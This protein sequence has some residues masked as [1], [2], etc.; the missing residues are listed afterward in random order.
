M[1]GKG[2][3]RSTGAQGES[4]INTGQFLCSVIN[5]LMSCDKPTSS[6]H[7]LH[8]Y[9]YISQSMSSSIIDIER[10]DSSSCAMLKVAKCIL[11]KPG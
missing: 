7:Q 5:L 10:S 1:F 4:L 9:R 6:D 8:R 11:K 3:Q 2:A